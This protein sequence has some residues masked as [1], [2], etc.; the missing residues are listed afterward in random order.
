MGFGAVHLAVLSSLLRRVLPSLSRLHTSAYN[1]LTTTRYRSSSR[2]LSSSLSYQPSRGRN[3]PIIRP[4]HFA[5]S[6]LSSPAR[7]YHA[8]AW[9]RESLYLAAL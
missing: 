1:L 4:D 8:A 9:P 5:P 6:L 2:Q 3:H 7:D